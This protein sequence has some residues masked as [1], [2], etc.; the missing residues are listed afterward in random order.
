LKAEPD[1]TVTPTGCP[2][3]G[4]GQVHGKV[5]RYFLKTSWQEYRTEVTKEL[6]MKVANTIGVSFYNKGKHVPKDFEC[7]FVKGSAEKS[8]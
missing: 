6:Y 5:T 4:R 3:K 2:I 1:N 7:G 8:K